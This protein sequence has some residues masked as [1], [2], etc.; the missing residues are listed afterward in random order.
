MEL[1]PTGGKSL[2]ESARDLGIYDWALGH[3]VQQARL[4]RA[5]QKGLSIEEHTRLRELE[6]EE[7]KLQMGR[8]LLKRA[9]AFWGRESSG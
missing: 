3:W 9:T 8:A 7:A 5:E 4:E 6:Q 2:A 1:V